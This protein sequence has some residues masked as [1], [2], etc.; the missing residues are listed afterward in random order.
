MV[1]NIGG[2]EN[3]KNDKI[4]KEKQ[5]IITS[6]SEKKLDKNLINKI[7]KYGFKNLNRF[8]KLTILCLISFMSYHFYDLIKERKRQFPKE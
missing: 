5:K 7:Q 8:K 2:K 6:P 4:F 3:D 1:K